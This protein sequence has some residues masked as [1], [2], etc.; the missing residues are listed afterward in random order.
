MG[1]SQG[2]IADLSAEERDCL[3]IVL[4]DD[5]FAEFE[6]GERL[7]TDEEGTAGEVCFPE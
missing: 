3:R 6:A 7:P 5:V 2:A 4:G 1:E